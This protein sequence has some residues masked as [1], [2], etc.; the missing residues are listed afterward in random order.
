MSRRAPGR[1]VVTLAATGLDVAIEDVPDDP[2]LEV[3]EFLA[4]YYGYTPQ[5][6]SAELLELGYVQQI[7]M[8][9]R[10][11]WIAI[12]GPRPSSSR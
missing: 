10:G 8:Q 6:T 11:Q 2:S 1:V 9:Q 3:R 5:I 4:R 12:Y 7:R